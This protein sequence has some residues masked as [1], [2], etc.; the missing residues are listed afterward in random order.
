[1]TAEML[2][3]AVAV[4]HGLPFQ[5]LLLVGIILVLLHMERLSVD[6]QCD[7]K[8]SWPD[9]ANVKFAFSGRAC[10]AAKPKTRSTS[11]MYTDNSP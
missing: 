2:S 4:L 6:P 7:F 9:F 5:A 3:N 1:M 11:G 8:G 10:N